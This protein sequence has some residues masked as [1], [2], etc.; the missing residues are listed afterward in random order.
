MALP[1]K[2]IWSVRPQ[3]GA[4]VLPR[5]VLDVARVAVEHDDGQDTPLEEVFIVVGRT[6]REQPPSRHVEPAETGGL[7]LGMGAP[8]CGRR[9]DG[10]SLPRS[11][12]ERAEAAMGVQ[13]VA[14]DR[15][16]AVRE[17]ASGRGEGDAPA[18][19]SARAAVHGGESR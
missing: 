19:A 5:A 16:V 13:V 11:M 17:I 18:G 4:L 14:A 8:L 10:R 15:V 3:E 1:R 12:E 7:L 6:L 9:G 2:R